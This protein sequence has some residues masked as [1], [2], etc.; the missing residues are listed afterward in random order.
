MPD[1]GENREIAQLIN[2]KEAEISS[3]SRKMLEKAKSQMKTFDKGRHPEEKHEPT[4]R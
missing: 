4:K 1:T 3:E 2:A